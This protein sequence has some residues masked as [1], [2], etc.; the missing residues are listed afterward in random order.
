MLTTQRKR[1]VEEH[2]RHDCEELDLVGCTIT[3]EE[4]RPV[5]PCLTT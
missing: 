2:F 1:T 3:I 4:A 5:V